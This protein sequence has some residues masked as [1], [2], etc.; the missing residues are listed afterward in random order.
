MILGYSGKCNSISINN[1][2]SNNSAAK[3]GHFVVGYSRV[4]WSV[5]EFSVFID[6]TRSCE[7]CVAGVGS[8]VCCHSCHLCH[9][10][11]CV[12]SFAQSISICV[13]R[14]SFMRFR[15]IRIA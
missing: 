7:G 10:C 15:A 4:L 11:V 12:C 9:S 14:P 3:Y 1:D 6:S 8:V 2:S 5:L 13:C